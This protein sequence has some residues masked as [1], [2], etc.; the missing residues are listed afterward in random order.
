VGEGRRRAA[1]EVEEVSTQRDTWNDWL[2]LP[3]TDRW[4]LRYILL[5]GLGGV[6]VGLGFV[7]DSRQLVSIGLWLCLPAVLWWVTVMVLLTW[8]K[9]RGQ[10]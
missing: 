1:G 10:S 8:S 7:R 2:V 3:F 4:V 6:L 9:L 5:S